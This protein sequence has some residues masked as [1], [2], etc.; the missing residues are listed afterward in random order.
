MRFTRARW[1]VG[2]LAV[3]AVASSACSG[4]TGGSTGAGSTPGGEPIKIAFIGTTESQVYNF[5]ESAAAVQARI[6]AQNKAGGVNGRQ[7]EAIV[8]NDK[9]DANEAAVCARS[10]QTE[11]A[12]AV[13]GGVSAVGNA[14]AGALDSY[15]IVYTGMRP[16][17][18]AETNAKVSFP[19]VGGG[20]S[21]GGGAGMYAVE[22]LGCK[23]P[24]TIAGDVPAN[25]A[26]TAGFVAGVKAAG[27]AAPQG[28]L[29]PA[30]V[31]DYAP[32]AAAAANAGA[33]C[34]YLAMSPEEIVKIVPAL[35]QAMPAAT[36]IGSSG[37][38]PPPTVKALG[39]RA[40]G[41]VLTDS[42]VPV[43]VTGNAVIDQFKAEMKENAPDA[44][45]DGF[46]LSSWFGTKVLI[47]RVLSTLDGQV[48]AKAV[49]NA[50]NALGD[51]R[52]DGVQGDFSFQ[53]PSPY[54][55]QPRL[56]N[57]TYVVLVVK[58][59]AQTLKD[60]A[61]FHDATKAMQALNS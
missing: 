14:L 48:D 3:L 1:L 29:T 21:S 7:L 33:D 40:E 45:V 2:S 55:A 46:A 8:C 23:T 4:S 51:I 26:T 22:G 17:A 37:A 5:A 13:V 34:I 42:L 61:E 59:G 57:R 20:S 58:G 30:A 53:T 54:A 36:L 43:G 52:G 49:L 39:D 15:G 56:F 38:F 9:A 19:L 32:T 31:A 18:P 44:A 50:Y 12:V 41:I 16:L 10:A 35:R 6:A 24:Y 27:G 28:V 60:G 47:D 11:G 25:R